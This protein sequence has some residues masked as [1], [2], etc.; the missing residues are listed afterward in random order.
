MVLHIDV[1]EL[2][3]GTVIE[4]NRVE[5]KAAGILRRRFIPSVHSPMT[6]RGPI[7]AIW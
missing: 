7:A 2:V 6:T 3:K 4:T 5:Y 1:S